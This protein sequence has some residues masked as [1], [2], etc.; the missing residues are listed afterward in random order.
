MRARIFALTLSCLAAS[1]VGCAEPSSTAVSP[2][3]VP[4]GFTRV[5]FELDKVP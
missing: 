3:A 1:V 4:A 2:A 5:A